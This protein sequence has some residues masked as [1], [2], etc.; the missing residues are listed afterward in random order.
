MIQHMFSLEECVEAGNRLSL[1]GVD[2]FAHCVCGVFKCVSKC[3]RVYIYQLRLSRFSFFWPCGISNL[4]LV[5]RYT[6]H[7]ENK[8]DI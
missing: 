8:L 2:L 4:R 3:V 1:L 5:N 7:L 6:V